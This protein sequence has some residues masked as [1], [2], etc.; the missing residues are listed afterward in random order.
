MVLASASPRRREMLAAAG[1]RFT[2]RPAEVDERPLPG[3]APVATVCRLAAA[4]AAAVA[5]L[6]PAELVLGADTMVF[7]DRHALGKP[8]D[9]DEARRML[10]LLSGRTHDVLTG[11]SLQRRTPPFERTWAARTA[12]RFRVLSAADIEAY[13]ARVH[14]LDKAGAYAIQEEGERLVAGIDG[15]RSNV[16]GL[17]LE[18]VLSA[19]AE[20]AAADAARGRL[21]LRPGAA[22]LKGES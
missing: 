18:E 14:T 21:A 17:P 1:V 4:K 8:A 2:C 11:V 6:F 13:L 3:E 12:V 7:C 20:F 16:V 10:A 5:A 22:R 15:L 19:L 9:L